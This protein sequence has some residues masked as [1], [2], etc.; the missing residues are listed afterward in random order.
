M[1]ETQKN[2]LRNAGSIPYIDG[3]DVDGIDA[4]DEEGER[5]EM[6]QNGTD[7]VTEKSVKMDEKCEKNSPGKKKK[8]SKSSRGISVAHTKQLFYQESLPSEDELDISVR[9]INRITSEDVHDNCIRSRH[10]SGNMADS[11]VTKVIQVDKSKIKERR[12]NR[13]HSGLMIENSFILIKFYLFQRD[14]H[15]G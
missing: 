13:Y 7:E 11:H 12:R 8:L 9:D 10:P 4:V 5:S 14:C 15:S 6:E 3:E 1:T 2:T